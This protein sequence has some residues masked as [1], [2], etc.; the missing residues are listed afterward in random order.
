MYTHKIKESD[1]IGMALTQTTIEE[2]S[3]PWKFTKMLQLSHNTCS[4]NVVN[5]SPKK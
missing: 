4:I 1:I 3:G 2:V 5:F